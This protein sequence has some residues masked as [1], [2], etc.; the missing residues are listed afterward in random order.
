MIGIFDASDPVLQKDFYFTT[1]YNT[2]TLQQAAT[3]QEKTAK[4][5]VSWSFEASLLKLPKMAKVII[6]WTGKLSQKSVPWCFYVLRWGW[7]FL[8]RTRTNNEI[9]FTMHLIESVVVETKWFVS[10][11]VNVILTRQTCGQR[12]SMSA[13]SKR[14]ALEN[15]F[16]KRICDMFL[17][18]KCRV[19]WNLGL[20]TASVL[21]KREPLRNFD[22]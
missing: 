7:E 11:S 8:K 19:H 3:Q 12:S 2:A 22:F 1:H 10:S 6:I 20:C 5:G 9:Q 4:P 18:S 21:L 14:R 13:E 15:Y 17:I 16:S